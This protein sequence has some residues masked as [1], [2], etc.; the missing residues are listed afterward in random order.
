[1]RHQWIGSLLVSMGCVVFPSAVGAA[2]VDQERVDA[3]AVDELQD[4]IHKA[5]RGVVN[6]LTCWIELPKQFH[7]GSQEDNPVTGMF[8]GLVKGTSLLFLRAGVGLYEAVTFPVPYPKDFASPYE[9]WE[10]PDYAWEL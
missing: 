4:P 7:L 1:M 5:G 8:W 2:E 6:V 9:Y 3:G 10:L